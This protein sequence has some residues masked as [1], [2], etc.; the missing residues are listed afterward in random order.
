MAEQPAVID[1]LSAPL[2]QIPKRRR[3]LSLPRAIPLA[4]A[5]ALA[6]G[7]AGFAGWVMVVDDPLGGEP[8]AIVSTRAPAKPDAGKPGG[9]APAPRESAAATPAAQGGTQTVTIIDG[10]SGQRQQVTIAAPQPA[11]SPAAAVQ[12]LSEPSRHGPIPRIT[13]DGVRPAEAFAEKPSAAAVRGGPRIAIV[14][15]RLGI[16]ASATT[17]A[18]TKLPG[19]VTFAF[20][21]YAKDLQR[22]VARAR[23][24]GHEVLLQVP[25]EPLDYPDNDAGPQTLLTSLSPDQNTDRLHWSMSRLQG[26][27]GVMNYMGARLLSSEPAVSM[28]AREAARRGLILV[29]DGASA[30]SIAG[31]IASGNG[32]PFARADIAID[33]APTPAEIDAALAKLEAIARERG[34][35]VGAA[36]ALPLSIDRIARW[37]KTLEARG[38]VLVPITNVIGKPKSS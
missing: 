38:I 11:V 14:V 3:R 27:V 26:Y 1:E 9:A 19:P 18:L 29:D 24:E 22:W 34:V 10:T 2:G 7:L 17:E 37:A 12:E 6:S 21:P 31:Q 35:A 13:P 30:R 36:S 20:T 15:G 4:I 25:M 33:A 32:V 16:S 8:V 5:A 23:G 28:V